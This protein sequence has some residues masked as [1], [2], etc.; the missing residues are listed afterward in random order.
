MAMT[1]GGAAG[2]TRWWMVALILGLP[3]LAVTGFLTLMA[4]WLLVG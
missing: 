3:V 2:Y 1:Q 4:V